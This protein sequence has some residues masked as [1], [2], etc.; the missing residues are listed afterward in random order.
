VQKLPLGVHIQLGEDAGSGA[1]R[2]PR[3]IKILESNGG[4]RAP[5]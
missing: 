5:E 2:K 1:L 3:L 4:K